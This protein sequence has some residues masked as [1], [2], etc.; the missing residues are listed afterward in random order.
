MRRGLL[1]LAVAAASASLPSEAL[2]TPGLASACRLDFQLFCPDVDPES[3]SAEIAACLRP[4]LR[5]LTEGCRAVLDPSTVPK[6]TPPTDAG[7]AS[8]QDDVREHCAE[9]FD[10]MS[11][12][13]C[14]RLEVRSFSP[15]CRDALTA[16]TKNRGG[17]GPDLDLGGKQGKP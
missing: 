15:A 4:H 9:A 1:A 8:C 11:L 2:A 17:I 10:G 16:R 14:I 12:A 5:S 13:R 6:Q 3:S 7:L